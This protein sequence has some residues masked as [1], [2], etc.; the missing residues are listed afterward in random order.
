MKISTMT[1][2][3]AAD[4]LC[5]IVEPIET[6]GM[7]AEFQAKLTDIAEKNK[8]RERAMNGV[9]S[10]TS[11]ISL[12]VPLLL[13]NCRQE[14]YTIL[15]ALTGKPVKEL[16]A[17]SVMQTMRDAKD[18][19]DQDLIDFFKSSAGMDGGHSSQPAPEE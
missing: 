11:L 18:C 17:Q 14:T 2:D 19:I 7:D 15:S 12:I 8:A 9:E 5:Q 3:Q 16:A 1:T 10:V 4:V 13:K 6:I